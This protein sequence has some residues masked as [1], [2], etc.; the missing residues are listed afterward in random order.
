M[1]L[2]DEP[3]RQPRNRVRE[4]TWAMIDQYLPDATWSELE[5]LLERDSD[6]RKEYI[7]A[8][9]LHADLSFMHA[10]IQCRKGPFLTPNRISRRDSC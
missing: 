3:K 8:M 9:Q 4:L 7:E 10:N 1:I 6:A 2:V 5:A